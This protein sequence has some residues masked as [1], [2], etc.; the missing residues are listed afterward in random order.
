M[1]FKDRFRD[2]RMETGYIEWVKLVIAI[3]LFIAPWV[4]ASGALR[5]TAAGGQT[6]GLAAFAW[7]AWIS[8]VLLAGIALAAST[9]RRL[10]LEWLMVVLGA[11]IFISPWVLD[12]VSPQLAGIDWSFWA[13][14][15]VTFFISLGEMR[16]AQPQVAAAQPGGANLA[17]AAD[18]PQ[19]DQRER[20]P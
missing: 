17:Y 11:W 3:W 8:A 5:A 12:F 13:V 7:N 1:A 18:R 20:R 16:L 9:E 15:A 2:M 14:G 19:L 10:S 4:L 6:A